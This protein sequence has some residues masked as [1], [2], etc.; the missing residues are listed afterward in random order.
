MKKIKS[1]I[2]SSLVL[3]MFSFLLQINVSA[4][5]YERPD[6]TSASSSVQKN[7]RNKFIKKIFIAFA[8][9]IM[10][11]IAIKVFY[12]MSY[13]SVLNRYCSAVEQ[14]NKETMFSIY[15]PAHLNKIASENNKGMKEI[16]KMLEKEAEYWH[17]VIGKECGD[18]FRVSYK[19]VGLRQNGMANDYMILRNHPRE[20][21]IYICSISTNSQ[22]KWRII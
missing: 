4:A 5:S 22:A 17:E 18:K 15:E 12:G 11:M 7:G 10:I 2:L 21:Y 13:R 19:I 3:V 16:E 1:I 20:W 14:A 8:F 9:I 6:Y